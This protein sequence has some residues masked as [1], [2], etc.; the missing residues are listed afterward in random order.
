VTA[1]VVSRSALGRWN[2]E[3]AADSRTAST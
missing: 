2:Q 1:T 3:L